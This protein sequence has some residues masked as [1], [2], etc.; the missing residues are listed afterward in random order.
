MISTQNHSKSIKKGAEFLLRLSVSV[1]KAK[2]IQPLALQQQE[3]RQL[4]LQQ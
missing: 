1:L 3:F 2:L 4:E